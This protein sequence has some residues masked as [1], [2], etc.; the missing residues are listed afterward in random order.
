MLALWWYVQPRR[1]TTATTIGYLYSNEIHDTG[2]NERW[3]HWSIPLSFWKHFQSGHCFTFSLST[4]SFPTV[5]SWCPCNLH[6][7]KSLI[8]R[9]RR[10]ILNIYEANDLPKLFASRMQNRLEVI[11]W[12]ALL[13]GNLWLFWNA[14]LTFLSILIGNARINKIMIIHKLFK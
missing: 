13:L 7:C 5:E 12:Y 3:S 4:N 10:K 2:L 9:G 6:A 11:T 14:F 8:D 1:C